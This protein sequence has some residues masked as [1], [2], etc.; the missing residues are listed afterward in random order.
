VNTFGKQR[1]GIV[2]LKQFR[3]AEHPEAAC[4]QA[5]VKTDFLIDKWHKLA[6]LPGKFAARIHNE[7]SMPIIDALGLT[8]GADGLVQT[9]QPFVMVYDCTVTAGTNLWV[10][11]GSAKTSL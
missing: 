11:P 1:I 3:D 6:P 7:A 5:V 10:A 9:L 2:S 8:V 4:Y